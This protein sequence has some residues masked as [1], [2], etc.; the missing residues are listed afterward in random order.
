MALI[1]IGLRPKSNRRTKVSISETIAKIYPFLTVQYRC[2]SCH[3]HSAPSGADRQLNIKC[4]SDLAFSN[5]RIG[6]P[7]PPSSVSVSYLSIC[8]RQYQSFYKFDM[9]K[10]QIILI[11]FNLIDQT[12]EGRNFFIKAKKMNRQ[13]ISKSIFSDVLQ[14]CKRILK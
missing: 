2:C 14:L 6:Y 12:F 5:I 11:C 3:L 8:K 10:I 7:L 1:K 4:R 13:K 9:T